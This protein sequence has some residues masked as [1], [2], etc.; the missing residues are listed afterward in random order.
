MGKASRAGTRCRRGLAIRL[1]N[2]MSGKASRRLRRK[3]IYARRQGPDAV[4]PYNRASRLPVAAPAN[5]PDPQHPWYL[6]LLATAR[7][8]L[9]ALGL[10]PA[11]RRVMRFARRHAPAA[12]KSSDLAYRARLAV[13]TATY[14]T[15]TNVHELPA[16][17]HYWSNRYLG[18][19]A[20]AAGF[21][22]PDEFFALQLCACYDRAAGGTRRFVSIGAGNC[23]TEVRVAKSV[24]ATGRAD[25]TIECLEINDAMLARGA[26]YAKAE[27]VAAQVL[28]VK[29]DFNFWRPAGKYDAI[30]ANQ[31]LHHVTELESLFDAVRAGLAPHG[32]FIVSDTIGRNGHMRWPEALAILHEFWRELPK[33][34]R[35]NHLLQRHEELYENWDCSGSG[36]E[37]IRAQDILPLLVERFSFELYVAFGN[38]ID[39][40]VDRAFGHNFDPASERDR[41][42]I[43]CVHARDE[44]EMR[45]GRLTPTHMF[46]VMHTGPQGEM[47]CVDGLTPAGSLR[48]ARP[49]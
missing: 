21:S 6:P 25:F 44:A 11:A 16:I 2:A 9:H 42:F 31:S 4:R 28:P 35:Y 45:A 3:T 32:R 5:M 48:K 18:P 24:V 29:A 47:R 30:M 19:K 26:E 43:D 34:Y 27:G 10:M 12:L 1:H 37:G 20:R 33:E 49:D 14:A 13:E 17:F 38:V 8:G 22:Q 23:D 41:A 39:V 7:R 46:A 15:Q 36:F 40:F